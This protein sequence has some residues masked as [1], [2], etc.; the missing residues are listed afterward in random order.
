MRPA[1]GEVLHFSEDPDIARFVPHVA[2][3][4]RQQ[5]AFV[6]AVSAEQA[7]AYWFPRQC[8]RMLAWP[9]PTTT[10]EDRALLGPGAH[11]VHMIEYGWLDAMRKAE[12]FA[13]RFAEKDFRPFGE[14]TAHAWVARSEVQPLGPAEPIGDLFA[15]HE[16]AGIELRVAASLW[17]FTDAVAASTLGFSGIRLRNARLDVGEPPQARPHHR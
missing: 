12:L 10:P 9:E 13:Y 7:P 4:A 2:A 11:R 15:L 1:A 17:P 16:A 8:P 3:T 14:P 6:W 5:E